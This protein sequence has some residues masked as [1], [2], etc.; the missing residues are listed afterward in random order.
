VNT[1]PL[2]YDPSWDPG[3]HS[4]FARTQK[5][6]IMFTA[7]R[8]ASLTQLVPLIAYE[9][10]SFLWYSALK[11]TDVSE[12]GILKRRSTSRP[13]G[14]IWQEPLQNLPLGVLGRQTGLWFAE[15]KVWSIVPKAA[16]HWGGDCSV[17]NDPF[18]V[19]GSTLSY[20]CLPPAWRSADGSCLISRFLWD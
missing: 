15:V 17:A 8:T 2:L 9:Y 18:G 11:V 13:H 16:L 20:A 14:A 1:F 3:T 7:V 6:N 12:M 4:N 19:P 10:G 5:S